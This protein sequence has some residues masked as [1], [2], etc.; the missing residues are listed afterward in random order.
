[1][2]EAEKLIWEV[3]LYI[4]SLMIFCYI[5]WVIKNAHMPGKK[6][7]VKYSLAQESLS[8]PGEAKPYGVSLEEK[9]FL[10]K[11]NARKI[12]S[13]HT[14]GDYT[15]ALLLKNHIETVADLRRGSLD[16]LLDLEQDK[17]GRFIQAFHEC[18]DFLKRAVFKKG[19]DY[20]SL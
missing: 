14:I 3:G 16:F 7:F 11:L 20:K 1:M 4:I 9:E 8:L 5:L 15:K 10:R 19:A 18:K 12:I 6:N 13:L 17:E 2:L